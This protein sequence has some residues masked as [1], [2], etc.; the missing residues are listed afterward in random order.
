MQSQRETETQETRAKFLP[1]GY[2]YNT[3]SDFRRTAA[4]LMRD[5]DQATEEQGKLL[6]AEAVRLVEASKRIDEQGDKSPADATE[7]PFS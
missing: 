1:R 2:L 3:A 6:R 4:R 7:L 5:A